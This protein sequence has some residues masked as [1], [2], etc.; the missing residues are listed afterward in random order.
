MRADDGEIMTD[1]SEPLVSSSAASPS[2]AST[3]SAPHQSL[4]PPFPPPPQM[5]DMFG[6]ENIRYDF[7]LGCRVQL[8]EGKWFI[9]LRDLDTDNV[10]FQATSGQ[11][12]VCSS[13]RFY[14]RF[15]IEIFRDEVPVFRHEYDCRD[16]DV[17]IQLPVGTLGDTIGWFSYIERFKEKHG[18]RITCTMSAAIIPLFEKAY[19]DIRLITEE[20]LKNKRD[21]LKFYATYTMGLFFEDKENIWQPSDFRLV[22]LHRTAGY[23]LGVDPTEEPPRIVLEDDSRPVDQPYVCIATQSSSQ[24]KYWNNP[25]GW[26][27]VIAFLKR[28]GYRVI[29][30]DQKRVHGTHP[31]WNHIPW[32]VEDQTGDHP[33][34]ERA[35]WLRHCE[36][37]IGLSSGLSWL[38]WAVG[39]KVVMISGFTHPVNEFH[40][41]WRIVNYHACNSCWNDPACLF[42]HAN[43]LWCPRHA[44]SDRAFECTRLMTAGHVIRV[45]KTIPGIQPEEI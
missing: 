44:G 33:L 28:C 17:L 5:P 31:V 21:V 15:G 29:C 43:F 10:L 11:A 3:G 45:L 39:A 9:R 24:C 30:I 14:V 4:K 13:K 35:R 12:T 32:G 18:C 40:T 6:P 19:P 2:S 1:V 25:Y 42:D 22:G 16:R 41:P 38:A 20:D 27:E 8:P 26:Q 37:F 23:I 7:N 34:T 36:F